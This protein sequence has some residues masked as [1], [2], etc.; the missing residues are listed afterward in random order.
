[1]D[2]D[3]LSQSYAVR[4]LGDDDIAMLFDLMKE[5]TIFYRYHPPFVTRES[6]LEDMK[7]LPPQKSDADKYYVGFFENQTLIAVMDLI[8]GYPTA[9]IAWIG[10]FMTDVTRQNK[11][12]GS[13]IV[14]EVCTCLKSSGYQTVRLGVDKGNPQSYAFW[15]KNQFKVIRT[16]EY[17]LMERRLTAD[18]SAAW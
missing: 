8:L 9:E 3:F 7:A 10:F 17:I 14:K 2:L 15:T 1:M 6:I 12:V 16:D 11:G 13:K 5:N 18:G 4:R